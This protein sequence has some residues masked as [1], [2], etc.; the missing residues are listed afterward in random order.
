MKN[1]DA[2]RDPRAARALLAQTRGSAG[3]PGAVREVWGG[4]A[5]NLVRFGIDRD[6]PGGLELLHGRGCPVCATPAETIEQAL[7][8]AG[9]AGVILA[10]P[11][12][13]LRVP[14]GCG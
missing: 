14:G 10:A 13:L 4:Q 3:R 9:R 7:A 6:L 12:D 1:L 5:H 11:G 2:Y 8:I